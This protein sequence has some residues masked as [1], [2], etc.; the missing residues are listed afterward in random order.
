MTMNRRPTKKVFSALLSSSSLEWCLFHAAMAER[1]GAMRGLSF[2][3]LNV[4]R[5]AFHITRF[6]THC[7]SLQ[8][9]SK[10]SDC[11]ICFIFISENLISRFQT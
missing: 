3:F 10:H 11:I 2:E 9:V 7:I 8:W 4:F 5:H 1:W 6:H